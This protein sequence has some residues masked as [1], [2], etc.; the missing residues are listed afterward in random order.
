MYAGTFKN[1][2]DYVLDKTEDNAMCGKTLK[3]SIGKQA[4]VI[5][6]AGKSES[7]GRLLT[8]SFAVEN[9][10]TN[11]FLAKSVLSRRSRK[12]HTCCFKRRYY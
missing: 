12:R 9:N 4:L 11:E 10:M 8:G 3:R 1:L 6:S 2:P 5:R 7:D